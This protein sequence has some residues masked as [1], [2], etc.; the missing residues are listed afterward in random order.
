MWW[1]FEWELCGQAHAPPSQSPVPSPSHPPLLA[2]HLP[3]HPSL[4]PCP[5]HPSATSVSIYPYPPSISSGPGG[6]VGRCEQAAPPVLGS[7]GG[8]QLDQCAS[9]TGPPCGPLTSRHVPSEPAPAGASAAQQ[10]RH[11]LLRAPFPGSTAAA[12]ASA[13]EKPWPQH[14]F[15]VIWVQGQPYAGPAG[16][17]AR[18]WQGLCA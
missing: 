13:E 1:G 17:P 11:R 4:H 18:R 9:L 5:I 7:H 12:L 14:H 10:T 2:L 16:H 15:P 8:Q 3:T 6:G